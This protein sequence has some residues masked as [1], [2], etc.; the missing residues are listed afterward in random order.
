MADLLKEA[1]AKLHVTLLD[2]KETAKMASHC[3]E[4]NVG[5]AKTKLVYI[6]EDIEEN[7]LVSIK[8]KTLLRIEETLINSNQQ[9]IVKLTRWT[10][11]DCI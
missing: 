9:L 8:A 4:S 2:H 5:I 6:D 11:L 10:L 7:Q 1:M 3:N